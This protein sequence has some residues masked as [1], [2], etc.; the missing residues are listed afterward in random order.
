MAWLIT[1]SALVLAGALGF[2]ASIGSR[3]FARRV[4]G[5]VAEL[6]AVRSE[7]RPVEPDVTRLPEPVRRYLEKAVG[8][9]SVRT[10][11]VRHGGRFRPS[12][13]GGWVPIR[14]EEW[15][16]SDPPGFVWWGRVRIAPGVWVDA[17][18]RSVAGHG[19]MF[20]ALESTLTLADAAGPELDQSAMQR[21]LGELVWLPTALA[22]A[23]YL[24]WTEIDEHRVRATLRVN[25]LTVSGE[26][27]L[28]DD[29]LPLVFRTERYRSVAAGKS[30]L[31]PFT[32]RFGD[33][34]QVD[35]LWVPHRLEGSWQI[36]GKDL[37]FAEFRVEELELDAHAPDASDE[38]STTW[39]RSELI[40]SAHHK[41]IMRRNAGT[42]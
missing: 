37:P 5:D 26:L 3:R 39:R 10:L 22:D 27:E 14:G 15:L 41:P 16:A 42:S 13:D 32:G 12:L 11:R 20:V 1:I 31:T 6:F 24:T 4:A 34:R 2:A 8:A 28:G 25:G 38:R 40:R 17:H 7:A 33:Y 36:D 29:D 9:R 23:R 19:G 35:G 30:V 18:D 21:L